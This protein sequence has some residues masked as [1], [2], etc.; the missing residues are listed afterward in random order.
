MVSGSLAVRQCGS[1]PIRAG[2]AYYSPSS[3]A[4]RARDTKP[5]REVAIKTH[6]SLYAAFADG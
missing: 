3:D 5:N 6:P 4:H 1:K 2:S